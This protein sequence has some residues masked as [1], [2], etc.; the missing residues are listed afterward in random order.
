MKKEE[1]MQNVMMLIFHAGNAK[2]TAL[3]SLDLATNGQFEQAKEKLE[4][5]KHQ[6]HE[7]HEIQ[8]NL[9]QAE[10]RGEEIEKTILLI[11]SQ[12]HYT[13]GTIVIELAE[14]M[15]NMQEKNAVQS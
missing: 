10:I 12:D 8:T 13:M 5:A 6:L 2:S 15:I 3:M 11:H 14:K 1:L 9:M 4:E 7:S